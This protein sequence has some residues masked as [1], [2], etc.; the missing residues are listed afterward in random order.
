MRTAAPCHGSLISRRAGQSVAA[1]KVV[2]EQG[3]P[4]HHRHDLA[5]T[6]DGDAEVRDDHAG[7][8]P[9]GPGGDDGTDRQAGRHRDR[10]FGLLV[11]HEQGEKLQLTG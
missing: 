9:C 4:G 5:D 8:E 6:V 3:L 11:R 10:S 1:V 2:G 7:T